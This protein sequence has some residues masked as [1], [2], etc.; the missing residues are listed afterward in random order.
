MTT[1]H[2]RSNLLDGAQLKHTL[3]FISIAY[4]WRIAHYRSMGGC[5]QNTVVTA[6]TGHDGMVVKTK[7]KSLRVITTRS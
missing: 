1:L 6:F 7:Q 4:C 3:Y 5:R 2:L